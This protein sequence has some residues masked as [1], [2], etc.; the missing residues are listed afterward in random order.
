LLSEIKHVSER[1][2]VLDEFATEEAPLH[3]LK[4]VRFSLLLLRWVWTHPLAG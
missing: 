3:V 1:Q 2:Y 4:S